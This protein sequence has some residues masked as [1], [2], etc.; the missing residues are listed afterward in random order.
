MR[1]PTMRNTLA[2]TCLMAVPPLGC[3]SS[4]EVARTRSPAGDVEGV[5]VE[6]NGGATTSFGY[7]VYVVPTGAST[8]W[9]TGV[10]SLYAARRSPTAYG[11]NLTW[12]TPDMMMIEYLEAQSADLLRERPL[13]IGTR[14][15]SVG[16]IS[17]ITDPKACPGGMLFNLQMSNLNGSDCGRSNEALR[18]T[19]PTPLR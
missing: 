1:S 6:T 2:L 4:D 12:P 17:G 19:W 13:T 11:V 5:V 16:L 7:V 9:R 18:H 8:F 3:V 15:I 14:T 10:A